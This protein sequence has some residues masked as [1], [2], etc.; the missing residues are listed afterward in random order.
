MEMLETM[1]TEI[2]MKPG[3]SLIL[4]QEDLS[5]NLFRESPERITQYFPRFLTPP[6][7]VMAKWR[8]DTTLILR[9]SA[10]PSTSVAV[11]VTEASTNLASSAPM[12]L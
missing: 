7:P 4:D 2:M 12:E 6:S 9:Q 10:R 1:E 11:M 5:R 3:V 8:A